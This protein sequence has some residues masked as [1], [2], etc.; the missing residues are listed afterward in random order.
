MHSSVTSVYKPHPEISR[1]PNLEAQILEKIK[2]MEFEV[3]V[4]LYCYKQTRTNWS[5]DPIFEDYHFKTRHKV[6]IP[7]PLKQNERVLSS[8]AIKI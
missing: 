7:L 4:Q 8:Q 3:P 5:F 1:T 2:T 6:E